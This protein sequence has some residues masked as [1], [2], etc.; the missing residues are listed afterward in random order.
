MLSGKPLKRIVLKIGSNA[1]SASW[2]GLD[3]AVLDR[4]AYVVS[5]WRR[6]DV[7]TVLVTSGALTAGMH[8]LGI[9]K[10]P[11]D[12]A[13]RQAAAAVGQGLLIERYSY[14]FEKY[15]LVCAQILLSRA[16]LVDAS[17]YDAARKTF[18][19]LLALGVVPIV[20]ENDT[21]AFE[22]LCFG[23]ND[24]LS[25]QAAGLVSADLLVLLT[26]VDGLYTAN[27]RRD[28]TARLIPRVED[29]EAVKAYA[30]GAG[31][32][33][34]TGGMRTKLQAAEIAARFGIGTFL[35]NGERTEELAALTAGHVPV[36]TYFTPAARS[37]KGKKR[38]IA[39]GALSLGSIAVDAGA[40]AALRD[41]GKSLLA[42]GVTGVEGQ[43]ERRDPVKIVGPGGE[44]VAR[45][46]AELSSAE[47]TA[48]RGCR[49]SEAS[50]R[51][52]GWRGE[53]I[54]HR[55]NMVIH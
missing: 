18:A 36:G 24:R 54:V 45:G 31:T 52:P 4:L 40:A 37:L 3:G 11:R 9:D 48:V 30:D 14:F 55:D 35:L 23:D 6:H 34:G 2:G 16:D 21:V 13:G 12:I 17:H 29:I 1:L 22:E 42:S 5:T 26:D 49:S 28:G 19:K 32:A 8:R 53:E 27:P 41:G 44:E 10:R 51:V 7:E 20:N 46:I 25:A 15:G 47:V 43:W 39:Y 50:E 33:A 38:W